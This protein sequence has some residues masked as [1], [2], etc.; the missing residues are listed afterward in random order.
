MKVEPTLGGLLIPTC[1]PHTLLYLPLNPNAR[2]ANTWWFSVIHQDKRGKWR[3][4]LKGRWERGANER[5]RCGGLLRS[6]GHRITVGRSPRTHD[7]VPLVCWQVKAPSA[8]LT[9]VATE[10][11]E[12]VPALS[13]RQPKLQRRPVFTA[14]VR[15][16]HNKSRG[17]RRSAFGCSPR[18]TTVWH[19]TGSRQ[20]ATR[21]VAWR[22]RRPTG[23]VTDAALLYIL[24]LKSCSF[25]CSI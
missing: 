11:A 24:S 25:F 4:P 18:S 17:L 15:G 6:H 12:E 7:G 16:A 14:K 22:G 21:R 19:R 3:R 9:T 1:I 23:G 10:E 5:V 8:H 20:D 13:E 2:P